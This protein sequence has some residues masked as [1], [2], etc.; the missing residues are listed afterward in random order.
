MSDKVFPYG[1]SAAEFEGYRNKEQLI[2]NTKLRKNEESFADAMIS[3][4]A[5]YM[6]DPDGAAIR[7]LIRKLGE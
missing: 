4:D 3:D 5:N 6:K 2:H 1:F 7:D